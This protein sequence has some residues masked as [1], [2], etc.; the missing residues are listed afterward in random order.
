MDTALDNPVWHALAALPD[1]LAVKASHSA[2]YAAEVAPFFAIDQA[3]PQAYA[4]MRALLDDASEARLFRPA[5]EP[6]PPGWRK[7]F[8]KP[9]AQM[10]LDRRIDEAVDAPAIDELGPDDLPEMLALAEQT[11]PGPFARRTREL[12]TFLGIRQNGRLVAMAGERFRLPGHVEISA[13]ATHP[14]CRGRGYARHLTAAL[15][16]RIQA[17]G[18]TPFLHVFPDNVAAARLYAAMGFAER[19]RLT[20]VWLAPA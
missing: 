9:I 11:R 8:E 20:I 15:A 5:P 7:T 10:L 6:S 2:R 16:A 17:A 4:D 18:P 13:I 12:G 3:A 19:A 1:G 14:A